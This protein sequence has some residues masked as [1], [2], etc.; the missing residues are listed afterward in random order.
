MTR[1]QTHRITQVS[2][3]RP[4]RTLATLALVFATSLAFAALSILCAQQPHEEGR[5][6]V[7]DSDFPG[8]NVI[9][10][11]IS[12]DGLV[13]LRPDLR[14]TQGDWFYTAFRVRGAQGRALRFQFDKPDRIGPRGPAVSVDHCQ[15]WRFLNPTPN[16]DSQSFEFT[17][18]PDETEVYFALSS[19]YT[20]AN[21]NAF[22]QRYADRSDMIFSTLCQARDGSDVHM[23]RVESGDQDA[24]QILVAITARHHCCEAV[25]SYVLE[26]ML[27]Q[28][29]ADDEIGRAL[30]RQCAFLI[31]P[32]MDEPGVEAGDQGKNR[33]PHDHNR[34][35]AQEIYP[36]VKA[37]KNQVVEESRDKTLIFLDLHCPWIRG[38]QWNENIYSPGG[39]EERIAEELKRFSTILEREQAGKELPYLESNNL[40]FGVS[41]NTADNYQRPE[42]EPPTMSSRQWAASLSNALLAASFEVPYANAGGV[43]VSCDNAREFGRSLTRAL[44]IYLQDKE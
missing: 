25:A 12:N 19:L 3:H 13:K 17:F 7:I 21:W 18:K 32:M 40:P 8:G 39:P 1:R 20:R 22:A 14:D 27:D 34:D 33:I 16:A 42:G 5:V 24:K 26:G 44:Q 41:W 9:V 10:D 31:V 23:L 36:S 15:T 28:I 11:S 30:R 43:E 35:Y 29:A 6:C 4:K 2:P 37:F 38:G